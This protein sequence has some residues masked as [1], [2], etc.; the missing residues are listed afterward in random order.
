MPSAQYCRAR[1][2]P[3]CCS[4][5]AI[6]VATEDEAAS[7]SVLV[8]EA[9]PLLQKLC[10]GPEYRGLT[11]PEGSSVSMASLTTPPHN[12]QSTL[13]CGKLGACAAACCLLL[14]AFVLCCMVREAG[15]Q[16]S[17]CTKRVLQLISAVSIDVYYGS[18]EI[19]GSAICGCWQDVDEGASYIWDWECSFQS[20]GSTCR[21]PELRP[22]PYC[23]TRKLSLRA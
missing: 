18:N 7:L 10:A 4:S 17:A 15:Y 5:L 14:S 2:I 21:E 13:S 1:G 8:W 23:S 11:T 9:S 16:D 20:C 22:V 12:L 3:R 6:S 19:S